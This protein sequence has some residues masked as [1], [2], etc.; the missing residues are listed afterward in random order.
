M[1]LVSHFSFVSYCDFIEFVALK[2]MDAMEEAM[3]NVGV[4]EQTIA[5]LKGE[6]RDTI[7]LWRVWLGLSRGLH[8]LRY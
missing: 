4:D 8:K 7:S 5:E 6:H 3:K 2:N 1:S